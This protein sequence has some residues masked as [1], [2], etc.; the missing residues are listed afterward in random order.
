MANDP[1]V[2]LI[3]RRNDNPDLGEME[4][5]VEIEQQSTHKKRF[6]HLKGL[7]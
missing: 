3:E 5:D 4:L 7:L 6:S 1:R 2:S